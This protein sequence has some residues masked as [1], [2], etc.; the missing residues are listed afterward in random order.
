MQAKEFTEPYSLQSRSSLVS[1]I[2][3]FIFIHNLEVFASYQVISFELPMPIMILQGFMPGLAA[4][5]VIGLISGKAG[6]RALLSK[7]LIVRVGFR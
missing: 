2:T 5:I 6:I 4:V 7:L 3:Q 1:T